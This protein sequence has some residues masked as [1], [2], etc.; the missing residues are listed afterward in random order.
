MQKFIRA[1]DQVRQANGQAVSSKQPTKAA[2]AIFEE[3]RPQ[4]SGRERRNAYHLLFSA[5]AGT[6]A[7]A[8]MAVARA[9]LEERAPGHKFVLAHHA[10]TRHVHI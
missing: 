4:L 9:V 3:W 7:Q 8:I 2:A 1:F 5:R 10:E 6:D